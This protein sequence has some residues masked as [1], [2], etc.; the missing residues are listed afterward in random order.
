[1]S[2]THSLSSPPSP[3]RLAYLVSAYPAMSHTFI[4]REVL[5]LK[6]R[7]LDIVSASINPDARPLERLTDEERRERE[8]TYVL[9][10]HGLAGGLQAHAWALVN[11]P[12]GYLRG[13]KAALRRGGTLKQQAWNLFHLTE[14]FMVGRWMNQSGVRHLHVH[15]GTAA[16]SVASLARQT[17]PI[18][19]SMTVH[20]PDE[21]ANVREE[22]FAEKVEVTEFVVCISHFARGQ[23]MQ[24]SAPSGWHKLDVVRLGIFPDYG[25]H[26]RQAH[27]PGTF[28]MA[29]VGR[30]TPAKGQH[31]LMEALALLK[32]RGINHVRL[33]LGGN[34]PDEASLKQHAQALG[35]SDWVRFAGP[36]NQHEV[37]EL[38]ARSDAFVLP[39]FAEGIPVVLM[40]AM[41]FG[42]PCLSTRTAGIP[43]LI[44]DGVS[45]FLVAPSDVEGLA[46]RMGQLAIQPELCA[47]LGQTGRQVV[48]ERY[49]LD[50]NIDLLADTF[51]RHL[52]PTP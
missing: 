42:L 38:Y 48:L 4:L 26:V 3:L 11:H 52:A 28:E 31:L 8:L 5:G 2:M 29:C 6:A 13:L 21:F 35:V 33:T 18:T 30:L 47:K 44:E 16:A 9:K 46:E 51:R 32:G 40:E 27:P 19:L 23:T 17:F 41:S 39:S 22:H 10:N 24:H 20:G 36:L 1:M 14:A 49:N 34:G 12:G 43:E 45:G 25:D 7:G 50:I 15:F 37:R